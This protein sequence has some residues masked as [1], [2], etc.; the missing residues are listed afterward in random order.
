MHRRFGYPLGRGFDHEGGSAADLQTDVMRFMAIISLCLVAIFALVQSLPLDR[1][2]VQPPTP[3][4]LPSVPLA[5]PA[6]TPDAPP[7]SVAA[8]VPEPSAPTKVK[9]LQLPP[10]PAY[11]PPDAETQ[12]PIPLASTAASVPTAAPAPPSHDED[13][14]V[15]RF[16]SDRALFRLIESRTIALYAM[17]D[18]DTL[19]LQVG[20]GSTTFW[21]A[22]KP[23]QFHEMDDST[24]PA[25]VI[26]ALKRVANPDVTWGVTLP[27]DLRSQLNGYL[28]SHSGG[29]LIIGQD[30]E[31]RLE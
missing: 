1:R 8:S 11:S 25:R 2:V 10:A 29:T 21:S 18:D 16:E 23:R 5:E 28:N 12:D 7:P 27:T 3:T 15:L 17:R 6:A 19:R 9:T 31:L 4:A 22:E 24:V 14:F 30:G 20:G 13:G 26:S